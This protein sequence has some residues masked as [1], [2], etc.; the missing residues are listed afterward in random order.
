MLKLE[1]RSRAGN[2]SDKTNKYHKYTLGEA[3]RS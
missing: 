2:D 1:T 3:L